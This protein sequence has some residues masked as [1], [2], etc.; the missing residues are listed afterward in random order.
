MEIPDLWMRK[1]ETVK[2]GN[3]VKG[4]I[5]STWTSQHCHSDSYNLDN[6]I[7]LAC[8]L[9][10]EYLNFLNISWTTKMLNKKFF[11]SYLEYILV[12]I[13]IYKNN[14]PLLWLLKIKALLRCP[15]LCLSPVVFCEYNTRNFFQFFSSW[16]TQIDWNILSEDCKNKLTT[17]MS[18][19]IWYSV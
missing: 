14:A 9:M 15:L 17:L 6:C 16:C 3:K 12:C 8:S 10:N 13:Y 7:S 5:Y 11:H 2:G 1:R 18:S 19:P 4:K